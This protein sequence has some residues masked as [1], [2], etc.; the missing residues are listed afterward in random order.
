M[1]TVQSPS[2][3]ES[4]VFPVLISGAGPIGLLLALQ[5]T[6]FNVP[7]R[8][9]DRSQTICP[10][11]RSLAIQPRALEILSM[12]DPQLWNTFLNRGQKIKNFHI[13]WGNSL[14]N[15]I[16]V[17]LG[18][19]TYFRYFLALEQCRTSELIMNRLNEL[20]VFVDYGW[21]LVDTKVVEDNGESYV[22]S[23][24]RKAKETSQENLADID[25]DTDILNS[26]IKIVGQVSQ[27][28]QEDG[29]EYEVQVVRSRYLV[30]S[31]GGR[32]TVRH[33]LKIPFNGC[34]LKHKTFMFD[35]TIET[36]MSLIGN[37][38]AIVGSN[39]VPMECIP[40]SNGN[41]R[42]TVVGGDVEP[43][44]D[45]TQTVKE[46][47]PERLEEMVRGIIAPA[48]FKILRASWIS[49]FQVNERRAE[50]FVQKNKIFLAGD[51]AHTHSSSGGYG[52]GTG[53][54]DAHNLAWKLALVHQ[55]LA[56]ESL[57]ETYREREPIADLSIKLSG[58]FLR[59]H[60]SKNI[61]RYLVVAFAKVLPHI[62]SFLKLISVSPPE[63]MMLR[64]SYPQNSL[65]IPHATQKKPGVEAAVGARAPDA[66]LKVISSSEGQQVE[67]KTEEPLRV[68]DL[69]VGLGQ[70]NIMVFTGTTLDPKSKGNDI[71]TPASRLHSVI[72]SRLT[73]WR[74]RWYYEAESKDRP[75][76]K[77]LLRLHVVATATAPIH[78]DN[79]VEALA[80]QANGN[81]EVYLDESSLA[82]TRY[83]LDARNGPTSGGIVVVRP[84]AH[85]GY[86]VQ[87][88]GESAWNDVERYLESIL[89]SK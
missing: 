57:L 7:V 6:K 89:I 20:G 61:F 37:L 62:L 72:Q 70:F 60:H 10:L 49:V 36:D 43:N 13:W 5:L 71:S 58:A 76:P 24:I 30:G 74:Y 46:L 52:L 16:P 38:S 25:S 83:E 78:E 27:Y 54:Q 75:M 53:M 50:T 55:G 56:H 14:I 21:E 12:I 79:G 29:R 17:I 66:S 65:N 9:I 44:E 23:T 88:T 47:T 85:I 32:S 18:E 87:G 40:L 8:I 3:T 31:D 11:S 86:R 80:G 35:G 4:H 26:D 41:M 84:D 77:H 28:I 33:K 22:E 59:V 39:K 81:G 82:H 34:T 19:N 51:A 73:A 68:Y 42:T 2:A 1:T 67:S 63:I 15:T 69:F 48:S 64:I 45:L